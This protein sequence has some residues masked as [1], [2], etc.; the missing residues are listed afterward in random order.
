MIDSFVF[1]ECFFAC[2]IDERGTVGEALPHRSLEG[3]SLFSGFGLGVVLEE[4]GAD[5]IGRVRA[6]VAAM[7]DD[8]DDC[9]DSRSNIDKNNDG[10]SAV[11][12]HK[13]TCWWYGGMR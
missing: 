8:N 4:G 7:D 5:R 9:D 11:L 2:L 6:D 13:R 10:S 3:M 1:Q 12:L